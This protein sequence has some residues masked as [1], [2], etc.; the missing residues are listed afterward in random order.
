MQQCFLIPYIQNACENW[1]NNKGIIDWK[2]LPTD[3]THFNIRGLDVLKI[4]QTRVYKWENEIKKW[5]DI[6]KF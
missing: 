5:F 6:T 4:E 3:T 1:F 2:L